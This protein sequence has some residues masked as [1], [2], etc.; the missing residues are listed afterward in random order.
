MGSVVGA[1]RHSPQQPPDPSGNSVAI[2]DTDSCL[3]HPVLIIRDGTDYHSVSESVMSSEFETTSFLDQGGCTHNRL[4]VCL[5]VCVY[6]HVCGACV[7]ACV[8]ACM[9][10]CVCV[11][12][13]VCVHAPVCACVCTYLCLYVCLFV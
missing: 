2:G 12:V 6:V 4:E 13:C 11:R 3:S 8:R 7:R 9:C 5:C 10:V 1:S